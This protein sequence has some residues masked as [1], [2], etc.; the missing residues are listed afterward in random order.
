[1]YYKILQTPETVNTGKMYAHFLFLTYNV[2]DANV[3]ASQLLN[4]SHL[5]D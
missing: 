5:L 4:V 3:Y 1:M 2:A